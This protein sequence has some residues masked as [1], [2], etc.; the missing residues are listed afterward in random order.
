MPETEER[1]KLREHFLEMFIRELLTN[2][3]DPQKDKEL[4]QEIM[5]EKLADMTTDLKKNQAVSVK[6]MSGPAYTSGM[7]L[8]KPQESISP[9]GS[10]QFPQNYSLV[11]P[12][13]SYPASHI[14]AIPRYSPIPLPAYQPT[15]YHPGQKV[16]TI[17]LGKLASILQDPA[18]IGVECPGPYKNLIVNRGGSIQTSSVTLTPEEINTVMHNISEHTRI[19]ITPGVFRAAVQDLLVT[20]VVSDFVGTRFLLQK[21]NPFQ[22]Y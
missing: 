10:P 1:H 14:Q 20:A 3:Y 5:K 11:E 7:P 4:Q 6:E 12:P 16:E 9:A 2:S 8:P 15:K 18:V 22:R 13:R 21:R 17:N 19:P